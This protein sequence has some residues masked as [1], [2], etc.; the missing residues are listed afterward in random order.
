MKN[1][2]EFSAPFFILLHEL[3][4]PEKPV[5]L[6]LSPIFFSDQLRRTP[7]MQI[8]AVIATVL[9][10]IATLKL[11]LAERADLCDECICASNVELTGAA[12][13]YRAASSDRK[14]RG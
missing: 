10:S 7:S 8:G 13:F 12:R 6:S 9:A 11:P 3:Q 2:A 5:Y 1:G 4:C 14:E